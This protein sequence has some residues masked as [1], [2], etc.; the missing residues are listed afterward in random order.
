MAGAIASA[1]DLRFSALLAKPVASMI[2]R[3]S[4]RKVLGFSAM[5]AF[6]VLKAQQGCPSHSSRERM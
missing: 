4:A 1:I 6:D 5:N 2:A 3:L